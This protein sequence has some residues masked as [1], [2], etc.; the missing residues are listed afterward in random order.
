MK[1]SVWKGKCCAALRVI[2]RHFFCYSVSFR[3]IIK[4]LLGLKYFSMYTAR[5]Y[6]TMIANEYFERVKKK[7]ADILE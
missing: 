2:E 7:K 6:S 3:C 1:I 5:N 4:Q